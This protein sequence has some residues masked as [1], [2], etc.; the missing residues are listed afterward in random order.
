MEVDQ[1]ERTSEVMQHFF[2]G[3]GGHGNLA[4][5]ATPDCMTGESPGIWPKDYHTYNLLRQWR[6][7]I[8]SLVVI[9]AQ[10]M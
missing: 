7:A 1:S 10:F 3:G 9:F 6:I 4:T 8:N 2:V 5:L